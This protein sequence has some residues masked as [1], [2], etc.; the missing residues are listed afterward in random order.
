MGVYPGTIPWFLDHRRG[1]RWLFHRPRPRESRCGAGFAPGN[2]DLSLW[3]MRS[4]ARN[5]DRLVTVLTRLGDRTAGTSSGSSTTN[6]WRSSRLPAATCLCRRNGVSPSGGASCEGRL[7]GSEGPGKPG[8]DRGGSPSLDR[9]ACLRSHQR[10]FKGQ[11]FPCEASLW[12][13]SDHGISRT[14]LPEPAAKITPPLEAQHRPDAPVMRRPGCQ[15]AT[16][17]HVR[18]HG[19]IGQFTL[20]AH[21]NRSYSS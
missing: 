8:A 21:D 11:G 3:C 16:S 18:D 20:A 5:R 2:P 4:R 14:S 13:R 12:C 1:F 10:R 19:C 17:E 6:C 7:G 9:R 15:R